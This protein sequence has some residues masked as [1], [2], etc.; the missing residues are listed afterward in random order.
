MSAFDDAVV[1]DV[2]DAIC[3]TWPIPEPVTFH[4]VRDL[5]DTVT[6]AVIRHA[7]L[8]LEVDGRVVVF[9][10]PDDYASEDAADVFGQLGSELAD[11]GAVTLLVVTPG[12]DVS[13]LT[14]ADIPAKKPDD[15]PLGL[16]T[17]TLGG[18][19]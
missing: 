2:R 8:T 19:T 14:L 15:T 4:Q 17:N 13:T 9:R 18:D 7:I 6:A 5:L 12:F 11:A 10:V 1:V 3:R 16:P